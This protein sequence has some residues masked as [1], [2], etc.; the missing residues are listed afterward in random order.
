MPP[1]LRIAWLQ[2]QRCFFCFFF[3]FC[4]FFFSSSWRLPRWIVPF[5]AHCHRKH[6]A[7]RGWTGYIYSSELWWAW[8][9]H[10]LDR[11]GLYKAPTSLIESA[12]MARTIKKLPPS[13]LLESLNFPLAASCFSPSS[14]NKICS[15]VGQVT[16]STY[17]SPL[18]YSVPD[19][20]FVAKFP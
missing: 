10:E 1:P 5:H 18:T 20:I 12:D 8:A 17:V 2:T 15:M 16:V 14:I 9:S 3:W 11:I 7:P 6:R 4:F 13:T 19:I